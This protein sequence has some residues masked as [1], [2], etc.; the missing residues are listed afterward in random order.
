MIASILNELSK[1]DFD[2]RECAY[3][4]DPL[5][6]LFPEWVRYYRL[7]YA[8]AKTLQPRTILEVG[9]RFGYS[10]A[11]FL[12]AAPEAKFVG[13]DLNSDSFG[14]QVDAL[15]WARQITI[16]RDARFIVADSQKM[17]RFPG[18]T[19]D[20][21]HV[22]GQQDGGGTF[23]DLRRAVAQARWVLLDGYFWTQENFLNA[24]D[25]LL[26]YKDVVEYALTIPGYAG[27]L[28]LRVKDE[29]LVSC[30]AVPAAAPSESRQLTEFYDSNYYLNDCGGHREFRQ[31]GGQRVEDLRLLSL[32]MLTRLGSGGRA[33]DLGCGRGEI[34]CQLAWNAVPVT[35]IDYSAAAIELAKSCLSQAPEEVRRKA[36]FICGDVGELQLEDRFGVAI[37]GDLVEHLAPAEVARLYATLAKLL[38]SDGVF[39][40][41]T[42]PNLWRY[43][44]DHPRRR[45]AAGGLG[46]YLPVE[47]RTRYEL[48]MHINEQ[49]PARLRRAL[50]EFFPHVKVWVGSPTDPAGSLS[51]RFNFDE[52]TRAP[53][54]Y[55]LASHAPLDLAKAARVLT[56][57]GLPDGVHDNF[58]LRLNEWPLAA[59]AGSSFTLAV[60]VT[61]NSAHVISSLSPHPVRLSYH[62]TTL[63]KDRVIVFDGARSTLPFGVCPGETRVILAGIEAPREEGALL[64][65]VSL[66]QEG[67]CWFEEKAGFAPAEG[68]IAISPT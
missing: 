57:P 59:A 28:L 20:L 19:Y 53:D 67:C 14:G 15:A 24:N 34:T 32:L 31:S 62:W 45:A 55:A 8:I 26:K 13:I 46:A 48:L 7:K 35:A 40:I 64:L 50:C 61:N 11:A 44:R 38:D 23:H 68:V 21:I 9:V 16:G 5:S 65:S 60:S 43:T 18:D 52:L 27:E 4:N 33:L 25:F 47:P 12:A 56:M 41:H 2:F 30:A 10:A 36:R 29:F 1:S 49:T 54:I 39:V 37:A 63:S 66:V 6:A 17:E 58:S 3:P 42:A 22:D 51:R